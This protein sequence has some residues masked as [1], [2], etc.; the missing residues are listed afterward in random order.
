MH[1][2]AGRH[3]LAGLP[4]EYALVDLATAAPRKDQPSAYAIIDRLAGTFS[5][6][7]EERPN[8]KSVYLYSAEPGTGKTTTA[9]ALLNAYLRTHFVEA[10][11]L[12][13]TPHRKP[14]EFFDLNEYQTAYI[15]ASQMRDET[16]LQAIGRRLGSAAKVPFLVLDDVAIRSATENFRAMVHAVINARIASGLPTVYTSNVDMDGLE[17]VYD[18]RLADRI[19][20]KCQV[21]QFVGRSK[22][23]KRK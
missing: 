1:S 19:R 18:A 8:I 5:R 22:R 23:G 20:D 13:R 7:F 6:Q 14:A 4:S 9:A 3:T 2:A 17:A 15:L 11:R 10:A 16:Q 12:G 21:V